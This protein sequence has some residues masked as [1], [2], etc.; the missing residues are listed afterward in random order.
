MYIRYN[1][2]YITYNTVQ[3]KWFFK[4]SFGVIGYLRVYFYLLKG[5]LLGNL[6]DR[7]TLHRIVSYLN[8]LQSCFTSVA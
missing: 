2:I 7:G 8:L 3:I 1:G 4:G 6:S 5:V